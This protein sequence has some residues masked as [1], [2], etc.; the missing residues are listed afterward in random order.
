MRYADLSDIRHFVDGL[1][2]LLT[3][4]EIIAE[5]MK[6]VSTSRTA[7]DS[8]GLQRARLQA[9]N[10]NEELQTIRQQLAAANAEHASLVKQLQEIQGGICPF[11][12]EQC[13]QFDPSK[14]EVDLR[15]RSAAIEDL[16]KKRGIAESG[17]TDRAKSSTKRCARKKRIWPGRAVSLNRWS[18]I[19]SLPSSGCP[20]KRRA[21]SERVTTMGSSKLQFPGGPFLESCWMDDGNL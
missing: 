3:E 15:E 8:L 11:L 9:E 10:A 2:T 21:G 17:C 13:R 19:S 16:Q 14:V 6:R 18:S 4:Q 20:G 1:A 7:E 5:K 12:R